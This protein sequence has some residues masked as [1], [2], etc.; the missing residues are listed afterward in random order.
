MLTPRR[1]HA[2]S[3]VADIS[4]I[5]PSTIMTT[6]PAPA[7]LKMMP[8]PM[9]SGIGSSTRGSKERSDGVPINAH[10]ARRI[11]RA[12]GAQ[13]HA[14]FAQLCEKA[15]LLVGREGLEPSTDGL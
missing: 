4:N 3:S 7:M 12:C 14:A 10:D 5:D 8:T 2:S 15:S 9:V 1:A 11:E 13:G 6:P